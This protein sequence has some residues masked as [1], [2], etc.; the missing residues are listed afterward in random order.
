M[1]VVSVDFFMQT[2]TEL[3][4]T[5]KIDWNSVLGNVLEQFG[6]TTGT[7]HRLDDNDGMLHVV[8][9][10]GIPEHIIPMVSVIPIGKGIAGVAAEKRQAVEICNLQQDDGGGVAKPAAK[11]TKVSGSVA[12]PLELENGDLR[13]TLGIGK[14]EPYQ[15]TST[16]KE[17]LSL[18]AGQIAQCI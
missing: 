7:I 11:D 3:L 16:E 10:Q 8:A 12:V 9:H 15:F 4:A 1:Q 5:N 6:C 18:I 2:I 17:T 13:G 14:Y